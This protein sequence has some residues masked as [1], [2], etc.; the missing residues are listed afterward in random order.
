M[1]LRAFV[2]LFSFF[3]NKIHS[4]KVPCFSCRQ[5]LLV[6]SFF[7]F[8]HR[9]QQNCP[10]IIM[11]M[12]PSVCDMV[13]VWEIHEKNKLLFLQPIVWIAA[14]QHLQLI[15]WYLLKRKC[16]CSL[17]PHI[18]IILIYHIGSLFTTTIL[19]LVLISS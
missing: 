2:V 15:A 11:M 9:P 16:C 14:I 5:F 8:F 18:Y 17:F 4:M 12:M 19:Y 1:H 3:E 7:F 6:L 13:N 10:N